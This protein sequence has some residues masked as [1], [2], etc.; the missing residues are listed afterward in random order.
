VSYSTPPDR[1]AK[2]AEMHVV[3]ASD[4][5]CGSLV[6]RVEMMTTLR[7]Q[8]IHTDAQNRPTVLVAGRPL[9]H[10]RDHCRDYRHRKG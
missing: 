10:H 4:A 5:P 7:Q 9:L 6:P 3:N 8:V 2:A 1:F